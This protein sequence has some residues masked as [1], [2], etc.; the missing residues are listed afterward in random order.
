MPHTPQTLA[1][2]SRY[3]VERCGRCG[4]RKNWLKGTRGRVNTIEYYRFHI[5]NFCQ[6]Y[7]ATKRVHRKVYRPHELVIRI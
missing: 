6:R 2:T 1:D 5:R 3:K 7:G 4:E